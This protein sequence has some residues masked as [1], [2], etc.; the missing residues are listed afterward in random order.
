MV[1]YRNSDSSDA[2]G[3][4][5]PNS[6]YTISSILL[7]H[8]YPGSENVAETW[9]TGDALD[10]RCH[11]PHLFSHSNRLLGLDNNFGQTART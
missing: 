3:Y 10:G 1:Q 6:D 7:L 8:L 5:I 11:A 2:F 9:L 4:I